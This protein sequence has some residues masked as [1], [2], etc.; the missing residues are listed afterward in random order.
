MRQRYRTLI[1]VI[2]SICMVTT[3]L[4]VSGVEKVEAASDGTEVVESTYK[5]I[6][7]HNVDVD[8]F[9]AVN[10]EDTSIPW[11][12]TDAEYGLDNT[13]WVEEEIRSDG[14]ERI[15]RLKNYATD[16]YIGVENG[17]LKM[18]PNDGSNAVEWAVEVKWDDEGAW[19]GRHDFPWN[20]YRTLANDDKQ[21]LCT[22][23]L[24]NS[25]GKLELVT[26]DNDSWWSNEWKYVDVKEEDLVTIPGEKAS[27]SKRE[28]LN[29]T[30][31]E[32]EQLIAG[33]AEEEYRTESLSNFKSVLGLAQRVAASGNY[34]ELT[35]DAQIG[36]V[37]E[38]IASLER[39]VDSQLYEPGNMAIAGTDTIGDDGEYYLDLQ[40]EFDGDSLNSDIWLDEYL[41]HWTSDE[42]KSV[43]RY[44]IRDGKLV[45][46]VDENDGPWSENDGNV[47]V[48]GIT[49]YNRNYLHNF[50][51][52]NTL[53]EHPDSVKTDNNFFDGYTTQYGYI[54]MRAKLHYDGGGGHQALWLVGTQDDTGDWANSKQ[55]A[56]IDM[57]ETS[58]YNTY[59]TWR[60]CV[61]GWRDDSFLGY[62]WN[63]KEQRIQGDASKE[64]HTY[65]MEWTPNALYFYYDG[66]LMDTVNNAP[67]YAM[68]FIL[69]IYV[70]AGWSYNGGPVDG[71][72]EFEVDYLRV[73]KPIGGY[74]GGY[75][76]LTALERLVQ[77]A[78][79]ESNRQDVYTEESIQHLKDE[80]SV[81]KACLKA[82]NTTKEDVEKETS[83]LQTALNQL[84][85]IT[86]H[87]HTWKTEW[88]SDEQ[89]HWHVC[90]GCD[91]K[92]DLEAHIPGPEATETTPQTCTV[93]GYIINP[94]KE[95]KDVND[96]SYAKVKGYTY[97]GKAIEPAIEVSDGDYKLELGTDYTVAYENNT[98]VGT[99]NIKVKGIGNYKSEKVL[100]FNILQK[101]INA[102]NMSISDIGTLVYTGKEIKPSITL[103][104]DDKALE[105]G[106]DYTITYKNNKSMG[107]ASATIEGIGNYKSKKTKTFAIIP[108]Q[109]LKTK[110]I[111]SSYNSIT[112]TWSKLSN[113]TGYRIYRSTN[114]KSFSCIVTL[115][116]SDV[117]RYTDKS[118]TTGKNYYYKVR[119]YFDDTNIDKRYYGAMSDIVK[120]KPLPGKVT[121]KSVVNSSAKKAT[122]SWSKVTG[123]SGYEI[124]QSDSKNGTYIRVKTVTSGS[125]LSFTK[126]NLKVGK[127]YYYKMRAYKTVDGS[128]KYGSYSDI[129]SVKVKK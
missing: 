32:A 4:A 56:E 15:V 120:E 102:P 93:C 123:A 72:K 79:S 20:R 114:G 128:K 83:N 115:K 95:L 105:L 11:A 35:A 38:A 103:K 43:A 104:H 3:L 84:Q 94:V 24:G 119:A 121:I 10:E 122:L 36:A 40:E 9:M 61:T 46:K 53:Y 48:S 96:L 39:A 45:L 99:A 30:I 74:E 23:N 88:S 41:P 78:E 13:V 31:L 91:E 92:K 62:G 85:E 76:D 44:E 80:I 5:R 70:N 117:L 19:T 124:Y 69:S 106:K 63:T 98:E 55:T 116:G 25:G 29:Q 14:E 68:G 110:A 71:T 90:E 108:K 118:L 18:M 34:S 73:Y 66:Q 26:P 58:F 8:Y 113:V 50:S 33:E 47:V 129:K 16:T 100:S 126:A 54:E 77:K 97:T 87:E 65:G 1:S 127:T 86:V 107:R 17:E 101:N 6:Q 28:E 64:F 51:G 82:E 42:S 37:K 75:V 12:A 21:Y 109:V 111:V 112:L 89:N 57:L 59:N 125:T 81:A 52:H 22:Q 60:H 67:Q 49:T 7:C 2:M 27:D